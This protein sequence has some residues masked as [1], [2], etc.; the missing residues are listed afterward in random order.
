MAKVEK[1]EQAVQAFQEGLSCSQAL[2]ATY[3]SELGLDSAAAIRIA[4]GFSSGMARLGRTCGAVTGAMMVIGLA[5]DYTPDSLPKREQLFEKVRALWNRFEQRNG[6][7]ECRILVGCDLSN[8]E[9]RLMAKDSGVLDRVC[10]KL[11]RDA[12]EILEELL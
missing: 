1:V 3:G 8:P 6:S 9:E 4:S 10:P 5:S 7:T 11:V 2:F 12:A